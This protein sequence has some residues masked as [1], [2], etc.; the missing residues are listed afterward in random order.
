MIDSVDHSILTILQ[1][2]GRISN[3]EIARRIGMAPS[4]VLERLR[5]LEERGIVKGYQPRLD[6]KALGLGVLAFVFVKTDDV[7]GEEKTAKLLAA[8]P[9]VQEVHHLAGEDCYLA[10]VRAPDTEALGRLLRE[11]VG[12]ISSVR[13]TRTTIV[14]GTAKESMALP[15]GP[16]SR[17]PKTEEA[18]R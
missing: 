12:A 16:E 9:E 7:S 6:A 18:N 14:L 1:E 17:T 5:K 8:M 4:G 11:K 15:L 3:A 10:K 13:S 2:D